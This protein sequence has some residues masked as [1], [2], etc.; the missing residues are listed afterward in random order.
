M[1]YKDRLG[2]IPANRSWVVTSPAS[3]T[4]TVTLASSSKPEA[5][6]ALVAKIQIAGSRF[7]T[8]EYRTKDSW[9]QGLNS[10]GVF[11]HLYNN[12]PQGGEAWGESVVQTASNGDQSMQVGD[13]FSGGGITVNVQSFNAAA[14]TATVSIRY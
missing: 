9:D 1:A 4:Q 7:Y 6:G 13:Q 2:W 5:N 11:V 10:A 3:K 8:V 12:A 14:G